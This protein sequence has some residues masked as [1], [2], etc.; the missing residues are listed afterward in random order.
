MFDSIPINNTYIHEFK[1]ILNTEYSKEKWESLISSKTYMFK[2][3]WKD[4]F[5][6][7]TE[8]DKP[9]FYKA[10]INDFELK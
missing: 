10:L 3:S 5:Y 4:E 6:E 7:Y 2:L 8:N 1:N 9:T